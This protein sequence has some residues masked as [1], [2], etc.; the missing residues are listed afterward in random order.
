MMPLW[1]L[2]ELPPACCLKLVRFTCERSAGVFTVDSSDSSDSSVSAV[3]YSMC[4][5]RCCVTDTGLRPA[6]VH[7][8]FCAHKF[9]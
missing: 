3:A 1:L 2:L 4:C 7:I 5:Y 8:T 9:L 6:F